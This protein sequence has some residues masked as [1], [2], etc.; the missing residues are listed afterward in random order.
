LCTIII[1]PTERSLRSSSSKQANTYC[2]VTH[3]IFAESVITRSIWP[4]CEVPLS[5]VGSMDVCRAGTPRSH[6]SPRSSVQGGQLRC[7]GDRSLGRR[8]PRAYESQPFLAEPRESHLPQNGSSRERVRR[9][10][11]RAGLPPQDRA[12]LALDIRSRLLCFI[13]PGVPVG[14][15]SSESCLD[16]D[17]GIGRG[18]CGHL[19]G[20][21]KAW[22]L[23]SERAPKSRLIRMV[24]YVVWTYGR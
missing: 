12:A 10:S 13:G 3:R 4:T 2:V 15:T 18:G 11:R 9:A 14:I 8:K 5:L 16:L 7:G 6:V 22:V 1:I 19:I 17:S 20:G 21:L 23:I 24:Q